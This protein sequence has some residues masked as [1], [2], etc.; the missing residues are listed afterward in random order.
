[1]EEENEKIIAILPPTQE[2]WIVSC[3]QRNQERVG[4]KIKITNGN[5]FFRFF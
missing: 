3:R 1:M 5:I 4:E 2:T